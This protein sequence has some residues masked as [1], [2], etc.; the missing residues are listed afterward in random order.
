MNWNWLLVLGGALMVLGSFLPWDQASAFLIQISRNGMQ[1]GANR[2]FSVD[3]LATLLFGIGAVGAGW[4]RLSA[5]ATPRIARWSPPWLGLA[6]IVISGWDLHEI[7]NFNNTIKSTIVTASIGYGLWLV[8]VGSVA[9][10]LGGLRGPKSRSAEAVPEPTR[11]QQAVSLVAVLAIIGFSAAVLAGT[12]TSSSTGAVGTTSTT[13]A[14][15]TTTTTTLAPGKLGMAFSISDQSG[16]DVDVE[17]Y[18]VIDPA[19]PDNEFDAAPA[20]QRL[21]AVQMGV[22]NEASTPFTDDMDF[23]TTLIGSNSQTYTAA[24]N[25]I[26][27]CTNF[28]NGTVD[29]TKGSTAVG[30]VVFDLPT[31]VSSAQVDFKPEGDFGGSPVQWN[32]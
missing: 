22:R 31:G 16:D 25:G 24:F 27:N 11:L 28:D 32:V 15:S 5:G 26:S 13:L 23:D 9:V 7:S 30:C 17:V 21:V 18:K 12:N 10:L 8:L 20:G 2:G 4:A 6:G 19:T 3:G 29:L 14:P 1:L